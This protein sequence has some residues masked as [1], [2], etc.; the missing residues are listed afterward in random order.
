MKN[1]H[2]P[3]QPRLRGFAGVNDVY[4][5]SRVSPTED[6]NYRQNGISVREMSSGAHDSLN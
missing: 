5:Q 4:G 6:N 1:K 2:T 3:R